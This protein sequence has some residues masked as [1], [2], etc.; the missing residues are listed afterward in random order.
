MAGLGAH[1]SRRRAISVEQWMAA[2][3]LSEGA[4]PTRDR[5]AAALGCNVSSLHLRAA[6][7]LWLPVD[8]RPVPTRE[9]WED[10]MRI[11][12]E[13]AR[14]DVA[15]RHDALLV[16]R[17]ARDRAQQAEA[18]FA[19]PNLAG[20][21]LAA[22]HL[23]GTRLDD[24]HLA[25]TGPADMVPA[26]MVP[27]DTG[28]AG[29][30][31]DPWGAGWAENGDVVRDPIRVVARPLRG[32]AADDADA[33]DDPDGVSA[34]AGEADA[35]DASA[36]LARGAR[37]LSRR[38]SRLMRLAERG[39]AISKQ[40]IDNLTAMTRMMDRWETLARERATREETDRDG[41]IAEA[42]RTIDRRILTLARQEAERLVAAR[43]A[44]GDR[45]RD[46]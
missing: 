8:F 40:E 34:E 22:P 12:R 3:A 27:T 7:E 32:E 21:S 18:R 46:Q 24:P 35:D 36:M 2:R 16:E 37:F 28:A 26:E 15:K 33:R 19:G 13:S 42:L 17:A 9:A 39:G 30:E 45:G 5:V 44:Q 4:P 23:A 31:A 41:Q 38:L 29:M 10:F 11:A 43:V 25:G 20:S 6:A 1:A 14:G